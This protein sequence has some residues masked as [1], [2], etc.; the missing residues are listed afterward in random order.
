MGRDNSSY[1]VPPSNGAP[2]PNYSVPNSNRNPST[3]ICPTCHNTYDTDDCPY[4]AHLHHHNGEPQYPHPPHHNHHH[5]DHCPKPKPPKSHYRIPVLEAFPWQESVKSKSIT[6]AP[7][8]VSKGDRYLIYKNGVGVWDRRR[9]YIAWYDGF[10]WHYDAPLPGWTVYVEDEDEFYRYTGTS[11]IPNSAQSTKLAKDNPYTILYVA[12]FTTEAADGT[13]EYP[14]YRISDA[15]NHIIT[16]NNN[17]DVPYVIKLHPGY[18]NETILIEHENLYNISIVGSGKT[19]TIINNPGNASL[20]SIFHNSNLNMLYFSNIGFN[21]PIAIKGDIQCSNLGLYL[22]FNDCAFNSNISLTNLS[23]P[24]FTS[25]CDISHNVD[26]CNIAKI[27][28]FH[29][30]NIYR[31]DINI[32]ISTNPN[33]EYPYYWE[34]FTQVV[35]HNSFQRPLRFSLVNGSSAKVFF[36]SGLDYGK[37]GVLYELPAN[38]TLECINSFIRG[39]IRVAGTLILSNSFVKGEIV[40]NGGLVD[41]KNQRAS[42]IYNDTNLA[43]D[44]IQEVVENLSEHIDSVEKR[45][46]Y[47]TK[48][49]AIIADPAFIHG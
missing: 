31:D 4:C 45:L 28:F 30:V 1:S 17:K 41:F 18:Y 5:H 26:L 34:G 49:Q 21:S 46:Q 47:D 12:P 38:V 25:T 6:E 11:W 35:F 3:Y 7:S 43:G 14:Y 40:S 8:I 42:Q 48:I 29:D 33:V 36:R 10:E 32:D 22:E 9:G 16:N 44:N 2:Y 13:A 19:A 37:D 39:S 15:I 24:I 20:R 23:H 27:E